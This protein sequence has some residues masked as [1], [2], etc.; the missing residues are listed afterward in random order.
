[1][2]VEFTIEN[3]RSIK[4]RTTFSMQT[5][6]YLRKL[7]D[8]NTLLTKPVNLLKSAVVFGPNGSGKTNLFKAIENIRIILLNYERNPMKHLNTLPFEPFKMVN[9]FENSFTLFEITLL[10]NGNLFKYII[11]YNAE[12]IFKEALYKIEEKA[13]LTIFERFYDTQSEKYNYNLSDF[14]EDLQSKTRKN[15][16]YL[17]VLADNNN[18]L[19]INIIL[20]FLKDVVFID[21]DSNVKNYE[22]L[23]DK[24]DD[25]ELKKK[26][27][28]F[29]KIADFNIV[30]IELRRRKE[31]FPKKYIKL[32][33]LLDVSNSEE[34]DYIEI[35]D[36]FTVYKKYNNGQEDGYS[37]LH[38]ES[39]E[40]R[41]TKK[42]ILIS[43]ILLDALE[44]GKTIFIDEFDNA[45]H[46]EISQ[47]LLKLFNSKFYNLNSQFILNTHDLSLMDGEVLRVDQI[48]FVEKDRENSSEFYSLYDFNETN[49]RSR[50]DMSFAKDYI[51]GKFGAVP[52]I[53]DSILTRNIFIKED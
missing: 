14:V 38:V 6:P 39:D 45:F 43:L 11:M 25:K 34:D 53:N 23:L 7:K 41:G 48:W 52:I 22:E 29:L 13:D 28:T 3:F 42:M 15:S 9:S 2:L 12:L 10:L 50:S 8:S 17:S 5:A 40:S 49:N 47:L 46:I 33:E 20:W 26:L 27:I 21:A 32:L 16:S 37:Y 51:R 44:N 4:N 1:M 31:K 35:T 30:D 24:L 18:Q 36:L 19:A